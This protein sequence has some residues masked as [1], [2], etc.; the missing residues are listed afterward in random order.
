MK[1]IITA[2][3]ILLCFAASAQTKTL[4]NP[5][6]G[7]KNSIMHFTDALGADSAFALPG[8]CG[9]PDTSY[10]HK[11][12]VKYRR[13]YIAVDTCSSTAYLFNP[14]TDLVS[15]IGGGGS[16]TVTSVAT[17]TGSGI[18]GGTITT[19]GTIAADTS[20]LSTKAHVADVLQ[21]YE[22]AF[23]VL[24]IAAGGTNN[25]SLS[26]TSQ[27]L[28]ITDGSKLIGLA[29]GT[30][31]QRL[32]VVGGNLTWT[33]TTANS[34]AGLANVYAPL[35]KSGDTVSQRYNVLH[36]GATGDSTQDATPAIQAAINACVANGGVCE[37]I[38][39]VGFYS[40]NG[41]LVTSENGVNP[42]AQIYIP[43]VAADNR[44]RGH[45]TFKGEAA[46][47]YTPEPLF[48][49]TGF[50][51]SGAVIHSKITGSGTNPCVFGGKGTVDFLYHY[52][53][54]EN[55]SILVAA[56]AGGSGPTMTAI[57][58]R[59]YASVEVKNCV[60]GVDTSIFKDTLPQNQVAGIITTLQG[61][62]VMSKIENTTVYGFRYGI[63]PGEHCYLD[64]VAV[65]GNYAGIL[66]L[67]NVHPVYGSKITSHWNKF[68]ILFNT[69]NSHLGVS[70]GTANFELS[71]LTVEVYNFNTRW[72][73][74]VATVTD[75][76]YLCKGK[77]LGYNVATQSGGGLVGNLVFTNYS[78]I[79]AAHDSAGF[80]VLTSPNTFNSAGSN[81][82]TINAS[83][84]NNAGVG[85][86]KANTRYW[87]LFTDILGGGNPNINLYN[88]RLSHDVLYAD[89]LNNLSLGTSAELGSTAPLY[90]P[91]ATGYTQI[92]ARLGIGIAPAAP[93][94]V[95]S[96]F[97]SGYGQFAIEDAS[98]SGTSSINYM[99]FRGADH[100]R[101]GLFGYGH[102]AG[103]SDP[104][105]YMAN[106]LSAGG[107]TFEN[108]SA[109]ILSIDN[110]GRMYV[111]GTA[112]TPSA[113][114][115]IAAG[116]ATA[117]T[118]PIKFTAGTVLSTPE[119]GV[120]ETNSSSELY[121]SNSTTTASRGYVH[122]DRYIAKTGTYTAAATDG[123]IECTSGTFTVTLPTAAS[124]AGR[125]YTIVN[126]GA[127]T[128]TIGT[129]SSQTFVNVVATPTTLTLA[130]VG[131]Y[132][133]QSNGA[134]WMV[135][136]N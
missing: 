41:A 55:L 45:I 114:I 37:I 93:L 7:N 119:A 10:F 79:Y 101:M 63:A 43:P 67:P 89:T 40:I 120:L 71:Q 61:G 29:K 15:A 123:T 5:P 46:P 68:D 49:N 84:G 117:S 25:G 133:V 87:A 83:S 24:P 57:D 32:N 27:N 124:I 109:N 130:A 59:Y 28:M 100:A 2:I 13:A 116:T 18:T 122:V 44:S 115:H 12:S 135:I 53:S 128:I 36:Y 74:N 75:S 56:N 76:S 70:T 129:T 121:Y 91:V 82:Q 9:T 77:I 54:F 118:S 111:G 51:R 48:Q 126:S 66:V 110:S 107:F 131:F 42:N 11:Y 80:A 3:S 103:G 113:K 4:I 34:A 81:I 104:I 88:S 127:G 47:N 69:V 99:S 106:E 105:F 20:I 50:P 86:A 8:L 35:I 1:Y 64:N 26:V 62:E 92:A 72:M 102:Y 98:A 22:P 90:I 112:T 52:V 136:S 30:N 39:P 108:A 19:T 65:N 134:N 60:V 97:V 38:F 94:H 14:A 6:T 33:D 132:T 73:N 21:G 78:P 31:G 85:F 23:S 16:G 96:A 17:N 58:G 125:V 95:R